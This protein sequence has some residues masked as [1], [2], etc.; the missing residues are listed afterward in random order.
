MNIYSIKDTKIGFTTVFT[1]PNNF[2]A[3]RLFADSCADEKS[4]LATHAEDFELYTLGK[5][6]DESGIIEPEVTYLERATT[7]KKGVKN[8]N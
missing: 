6:N 7:F 4:M 5:L 2:V 3:I 8:G 1:A